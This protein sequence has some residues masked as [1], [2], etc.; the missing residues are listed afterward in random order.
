MRHQ[1]KASQSD[2]RAFSRHEIRQPGRLLFVDQPCFVECIIANI[3][4]DGA[5]L[6][7]RMSVALPPLVLL[8][9]QQTGAIH[10]C[11]VRWRKERL[12]GVQFTDMCSRARR[13][14]AIE[15]GLLPREHS[16]AEAPAVH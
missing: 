5:L 9:E 2:R 12:V 15:S 7:M 10:E 6:S 16:H 14:A 8:W 4:V 13:R 3:S 1:G 11:R